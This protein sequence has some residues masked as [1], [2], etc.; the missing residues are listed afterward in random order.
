[1]CEWMSQ[2]TRTT[3]GRSNLHR[4]RAPAGVAAE[5]E[6][7]GA[8]QRE[9]VVVGAIAVGE[10]DDSA[11]RDGQ[12]PRYEGLVALVHDRAPGLRLVEGAARRGVEIDQAAPDVGRRRDRFAPPCSP[13][14]GRGAGGAASRRMSSRPR[15]RARLGPAWSAA[16]HRHRCGGAS[17]RATSGH[18]R[19]AAPHGHQ[20]H[21]RPGRRP[22]VSLRTR[23]ASGREL[24]C[25]TSLSAHAAVAPRRPPRFRPASPLPPTASAPWPVRRRRRRA[26]RRAPSH[27]RPA[28]LR[29]RPSP[30]RASAVSAGR[31][32]GSLVPTAVTTTCR[33]ARRAPPSG[34]PP[35][36]R[37]RRRR[38]AGSSRVCPAGGHRASACAPGRRRCARGAEAQRRV[39]PEHDA[40]SAASARRCRRR[41]ADWPASRRH[42]AHPLQRSGLD[43]P[44]L[45]RRCPSVRRR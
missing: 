8:R 28:A 32:R 26:V 10:V 18:D 6:A 21:A 42:R 25:P 34:R 3:P 40:A 19:D 7:L 23:P 43:H 31:R 13:T 30:H 17:D 22:A 11:G 12:Q 5:I 24:C 14:P 33:S 2:K 9:D 35:A 15:M 1:M 44:R 16:R 45:A 20:N 37:R 27:R 39:R 29:T 41:R 38:A 4:L 36:R